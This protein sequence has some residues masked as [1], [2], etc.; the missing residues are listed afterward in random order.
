M[1]EYLEQVE[2][3]KREREME[4]QDGELPPDME[5]LYQSLQTLVSADTKKLKKEVV[6]TRLDT[7]DQLDEKCL[8][9]SILQIFGM[10]PKFFESCKFVLSTRWNQCSENDVFKVQK[11]GSYKCCY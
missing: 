1:D 11:R 4:V 6:A 8:L 3:E 2:D 10:N 7:W 5:L 9:A